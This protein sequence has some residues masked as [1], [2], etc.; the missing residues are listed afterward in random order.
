MLYSNVRLTHIIHIAYKISNL[1]WFIIITLKYEK[2]KKKIH[3][4]RYSKN[5][6]LGEARNIAFV[7]FISNQLYF[8]IVLNI[9]AI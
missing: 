8:A 3:F 5:T 9:H 4:K 6:I 1:I 2:E 7:Y